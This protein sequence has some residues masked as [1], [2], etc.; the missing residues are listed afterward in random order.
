MFKFFHRRKTDLNSNVTA[1]ITSCGRPDLLSV[2]IESFFKFNTYPCKLL[3]IEDGEFCNQ[4]L[5]RKW[6]SP[7]VEWIATGRRVGQIAA[8]DYVYARVTTPYI[9]HCEDDWEFY[10]SGFVESSLTIL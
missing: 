5:S 1:V 6:N 3:V 8:V 7:I 2:T 10:E 9:F 4:K